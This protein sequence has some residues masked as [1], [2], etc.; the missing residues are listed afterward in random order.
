MTT[1][2]PPHLPL[3]LKLAYTAFMAVLVPVYWANYGPTNFLYFCD[4]ALF[5]TLAALW[6]QSS[7][8]ASMQAIAITL[9]QAVWVIDFLSFLLVR[10][11]VVDL[12]GYMF[13]G[14]RSLFLRGLSFF[15]FWLPFL[16]LWM[17]RR[18]GYDRR[19]L[20]IQMAFGS[21]LLLASYVLAP[22]PIDPRVGNVNKVHG[23]SETEPQTWMPPLLWLALL[24]VGTVLLIYV[25]THLLLARLM[26]KKPF[27]PGATRGGPQASGPPVRR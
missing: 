13:D 10:R 2:P 26:P 19:A 1:A 20:R 5:L 17:V 25:P 12:T 9:P 24:I 8:L 6:T 27:P 23:F 3:G 16:L 4:A 15:H 18:L 21:A 11:H 14:Q 7:T 22:L